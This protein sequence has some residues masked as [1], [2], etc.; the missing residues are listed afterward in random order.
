[1][2][3]A[4]CLNMIVR[5]ETAN[6]AR[7]LDAL[8]DHIDCWIIGDT[9]SSDGTQ[10][11]IT[12]FFAARKKPG[13]LHSFPF[14][15]FEQA[16][17][18]ALDRA[19]ASPL[20]FD[21][22][23]FA[24]ADM[25]LV[26]EDRGFRDRLDAPGYSL[27]QRAG[28][29][30]AYWNTRL[31]HRKA[32]GRYRGVTHEY[33]DVAAGV[34]EL[35]GAWYKDHADG[36]NRADK[37]ER[38][39]R[40]LTEALEQEPDNRRHWFYLA[41]S[42][43]DAGRTTEA[44]QAY[45]KRAEMGGWDEEAWNARL[46]EA[47]CLHGLGD[48]AGFVRA[49]LTA[50]NQRPQRAEPLY[51]LSRYYRE[52]G[53]N[54]ASALF[55]EA[56]LAIKRPEHDI[57]FL[58][59]NVYATGLVEEYSIAAN[60][61]RDPARKDRG[62]AACNWLAI[63][64]S[65][66][67]GTG[68]LARSN[69]FF[70]LEP[71]NAMLP[72]FVAHPVRFSLPDGYRPLNPSIARRG[73]QLV[74]V[75]RAANY[76]VT[77]D[78]L[79]YRTQ[80]GAPIETRNFLLHLSD[81][82]DV[83]SAAEILPPTDMPEPA[84]KLVRGF[85]DMRLFQW[86]GALWCSACVRELTPE[87]WCEQV[88]ARIADDG[89]G[90]CRLT[91][92]RVLR[93]EGPRAHQ[94]NWMPQADGGKL[95]FLYLCDPTRM[96]DDRGRTVMEDTPVISARRF[97]GGSQLIQFGGGWLALIHEVRWKPAEG[98]RSYQHRLVWFD[99]T[100]KLGRVSR[101]FFFHRKGIEFAAGLAWHPDG[102]RLLM[103]Y[104]VGDSESWIATVDAAE[105]KNA[106][107]D[108]ERLASGFS[109]LP[110]EASNLPVRKD[111]PEGIIVQTTIDGERIRFFVTN[112]DDAI[113]KFHYQ[114]AFYETEE[115]DLI[116]RH[117][118]RG[119]TFV[120]IGANIGNHAIYVSR[121]TKAPRIVVFEPNPAAISILRKNLA[122]NPCTN[123]DT[124]FLGV[125][126]GARKGRLRPETPDTNNLGGTCYHEDDLGGVQAVDGDALLLDEP[127]GFMKID[128]E[129]MEI[130]ILSGLHETIR[131]WR[132]TIFI[133]VWDSKAPAFQDWCTRESYR[134][135]DTYQRYDGIQNYLIKPLPL[136]P[137][138]AGIGIADGALHGQ[139]E[140]CQEPAL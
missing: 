29:G 96:V 11:F 99:G 121:F 33:L 39:I 75:Q 139:I 61:A 133:E 117:Y 67:G 120:D 132:P 80:D 83:Q 84:F 66:P 28:S 60:Y 90:T 12:S 50:F 63:N 137:F 127:I 81:E 119:G 107:E 62:F 113:M 20:G 108:V 5:N 97:S 72:S 42:Y 116:K 82:L 79:Q 48:D 102:R 89:T 104:G 103:S 105:V 71:A 123:I 128:V 112:C 78:G 93:P 111:Q 56:G 114:G 49:A 46:Q 30:L 47:R 4:I 3:Q 32:G 34:K 44:A 64:R 65:V 101:P 77:Q 138:E 24:D 130:E 98:R 110:S 88:L 17:N 43:R 87:G 115:L 91:D 85:E 16:R 7:C 73:E 14:G 52:K 131:R 135:V 9:G 38:D 54:D 15:N 27:L 40:L 35:R 13:E 118:T 51:D 41:Q 109:A 59:E 92:W 31:L 36:S 86:A 125:A 70:Y 69:M 129:G 10:D 100:G 136:I 76:T 19:R 37:F 74:M 2:T 26:V 94:K 95:Q 122:L 22:L 1:M 21:Y 68:E 18:A 134:V 106:L 6:L 25:E 55:S 126:L 8:V 53:M 124:A 58:E 45:A 140:G 23:L 57:L